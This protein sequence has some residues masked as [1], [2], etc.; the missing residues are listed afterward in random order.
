VTR[1]GLEDRSPVEAVVGGPLM[2]LFLSVCGMAIGLAIDC[3]SIPP[4]ALASLCLAKTTSLTGGLQAHLAVLPAT[5]ALM[6]AG[7]LV[8]G[9]MTDAATDEPGRHERSIAAMVARH[10]PNAICA[11]AMLAG[12]LAGGFL[13]P[14]L[15]E[16][17]GVASGF[18]RLTVAMVL[19]MAFGMVLATP[20]DRI[21]HRSVGRH[22]ETA[23][24]A[25]SM[26]RLPGFT[27]AE[28]R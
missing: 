28:D 1:L 4:D 8:S 3:G 23:S 27:P 19:G 24:A 10:L 13:G 20:L 25:C 12:M 21:R 17:L 7:A 5:H 22:G 11:A 2:M 15:V 16:R 6:L 9:A 26:T 14:P 18:T